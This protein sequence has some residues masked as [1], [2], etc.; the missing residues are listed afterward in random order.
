MSILAERNFSLISLPL[1]YFIG[2]LPH[3]I[4][5]GVLSNSGHKFNNLQPRQ[6]VEEASPALDSKSK[7]LIQR[8]EATH[9]NSLEIFPLFA[10]AILSAHIAKLPIRTRNLFA[11][12]FLTSRIA[13]NVIYVL[14]DSQK[15]AVRVLIILYL[16]KF[17]HKKIQA[18]RSIAWMIGV[19]SNFYIL[20]KSALNLCNV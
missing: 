6:N 4:K 17:T 7:R 20:T 16:Y 15:A 5:V 2:F 13:F 12:T 1:F 18:L 19:G 11:I 9:F 10:A 8:L 3:P 14:Q